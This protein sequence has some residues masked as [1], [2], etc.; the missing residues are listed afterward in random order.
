MADIVT[1]SL[2][3]RFARSGERIAADVVHRAGAR[4]QAER[5]T[6]GARIVL[7]FAANG[8][9]AEAKP[10]AAAWRVRFGELA[11]AVNRLRS[12]ADDSGMSA[13]DISM[14]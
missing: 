12:R 13:V 5:A 1:R 7:C 3:A 10:R 9:A 2:H 8:T 4:I 6:A 11:G 14:P